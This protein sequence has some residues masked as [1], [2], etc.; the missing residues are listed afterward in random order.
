MVLRDVATAHSNSGDIR[1]ES[2]SEDEDNF[3]KVD[4]L[5]LMMLL[6]S[7]RKHERPVIEGSDEPKLFR[8]GFPLQPN[9]HVTLVARNFKTVDDEFINAFFKSK[10][11]NVRKIDLSG[12]AIQNEKRLKM[13]LESNPYLEFMN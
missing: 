6:K 10:L 12:C 5:S 8:P 1:I 2:C 4:T 9:G 11:S 13:L 7:R 3:S